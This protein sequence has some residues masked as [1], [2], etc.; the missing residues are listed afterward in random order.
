M[1][2]LPSEVNVQYVWNKLKGVQFPFLYKGHRNEITEPV[3]GRFSYIYHNRRHQ[4]GG[5][6]HFICRNWFSPEALNWLLIRGLL[7]WFAICNAESDI[8]SSGYHCWTLWRMQGIIPQGCA[9][10]YLDRFC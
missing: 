7:G 10:P 1:L 6:I 4:C 9:C 2:V 3:G 5:P 8:A